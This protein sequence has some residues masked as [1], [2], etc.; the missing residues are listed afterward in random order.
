MFGVWGTGGR[1]Q[2]PPLFG[3]FDVISS[4]SIRLRPVG[5][6]YQS[7]RRSLYLIEGRKH[8]TKAF[9][10]SD[11]IAYYRFSTQQQ[12]RSG[13]GLQAQ[14]SIVAAFAQAEGLTVAAEYTEVETGK[15]ADALD[16]RPKL[17]A[18]LKHAK[19]LRVPVCVAKLDRLS[20]DVAFIA[21]LMSQRVQFI[22]TSLGRDVDPFTLHI[23]A[24]LAEQER[25]LISQ[26]TSAGLQAVKARGKKLGNPTLKA[27]PGTT[28]SEDNRAQAQAR[29]EA[30]RTTLT[31]LA[32][33]PSRA[34][35]D[36]LNQLGLQSPRGG[37]WSHTSAHRVMRRLGLRG[38]S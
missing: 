22:V 8:G 13:L 29:D 3:Y 31:P 15:G 10:M 23:Y 16:R 4:K 5:Q 34:V 19:R 12:G 27:K 9:Q 2:G 30:L 26:R 20:R 21:G 25:R 14:R 38:Q 24:A 11:I 1:G 37:S 33:M 17:A 32:G 7:K 18:A 35:A 28:L 36:H 6:K